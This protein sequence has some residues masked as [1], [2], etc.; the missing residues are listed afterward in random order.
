MGLRKY[1]IK[2]IVKNLEFLHGQNQL[3]HLDLK[4]DN[5]VIKDDF[6]TALIDFGHSES[7]NQLMSNENVGT[8]NYLPPEILKNKLTR[9]K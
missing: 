8:L 1:L 2:Q 6:T 3:A 9:R 7:V 5:I 4:P